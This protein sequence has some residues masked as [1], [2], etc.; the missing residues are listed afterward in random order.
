MERDKATGAGSGMF[1]SLLW[2]LVGSTHKQAAVH[3]QEKSLWRKSIG[4]LAASDISTAINACK[5][6]DSFIPNVFFATVG[7]SKM[8]SPEIEKVF[9]MLDQDKSWFIEQDELQLF[10]HYFSKE[11]RVLTADETKA[12]L[13][14][15]DIN[16]DGKIGWEELSALVKAS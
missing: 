16:G 6:K 15:G 9:K 5:V 12:F 3:P 7:L 8:Y 2:P 4:I 13:E 14:A 11:A 10:L 1:L